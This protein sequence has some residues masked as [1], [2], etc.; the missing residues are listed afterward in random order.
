VVARNVRG[1]MEATDLATS[2]GAPAWAWTRVISL[3]F[4]EDSFNQ[5]SPRTSSG[6]TTTASAGLTLK[7]RGLTDEPA[8][9]GDARFAKGG[10]MFWG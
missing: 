1:A 3:L 4:L 2:R 5:A 9:Y 10:P 8:R 6:L 7:T